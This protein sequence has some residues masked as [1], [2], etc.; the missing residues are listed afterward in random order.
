MP[1]RRFYSTALPPSASSTSQAWARRPRAPVN[2]EN[3]AILRASQQIA[4]GKYQE[5]IHEACAVIESKIVAIAEVHGKSV[6]HVRGD[7]HM[8]AQVSLKRH[9]RQ[10]GW[11]AFMWM[12]AK[13]EKE[14]RVENG[15]LLLTYR[16][17]TRADLDVIG[18]GMAGKE[19]LQDLVKRKKEQYV[20]LTKEE[21]DKLIEEPE[22]AK[23][24]QA[25]GFHP[26]ARSRINDV[27]KT[28]H[29]L[30]NEVWFTSVYSWIVYWHVIDC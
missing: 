24:T 7:V 8:G 2:K 20:E 16:T 15:R 5:A 29:V 26:S 23:A 9:S 27:T 14:N 30:E 18:S 25:K 17:D 4:S 28:L 10:S 12:E 11:N 22:M 6:K 1:A 21:K 19:V 13:K 3:L